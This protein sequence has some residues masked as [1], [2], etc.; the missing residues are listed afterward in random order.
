MK[1][2]KKYQ[3]RRMYDISEK[4]YITLNSLQQLIYKDQDLKIIDVKT[5][6]DI[7]KQVLIQTILEL[8]LL[9]LE[10]FSNENLTNLIKILSSEK[11]DSY[12]IFLQESTD[13]FTKIV[14]SEKIAQT[15]Y[16]RLSANKLT[17]FWQ[18][19]TGVKNE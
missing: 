14:E 17:K 15:N 8:N 16:E 10:K 11:K 12:N 7:T 4:K 9:G 18:S 19:I 5:S 3:N 6:E 2:I 13:H 1:I